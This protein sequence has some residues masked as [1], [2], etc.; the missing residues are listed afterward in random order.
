MITQ[1]VNRGGFQDLIEIQEPHIEAV[2]SA[3]VIAPEGT[4]LYGNATSNEEKRLKLQIYY[5]D[6]N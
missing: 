3:C 2:P 4:V 5:T 1:N 6:P